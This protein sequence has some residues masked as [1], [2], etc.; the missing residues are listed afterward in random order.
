MKF[1]KFVLI[2][3]ACV[4]LVISSISIYLGPDDLAKC[5]QTPSEGAGCEEADAIVAVSGGDTSARTEEAIKLYK[6]GWSTY[7]IFSGA[8]AD[9]SGPSN[10][11]VMRRQAIA[12][13]VDP[14]RIIIDEVSSTTEEN[15]KETKSIFDQ[16]KIKS[17]IIVTSQ[18]HQRRAMLEFQKRATDVSVRSSPTTYDE[19]WGIWWWLTPGGWITALAELFRSLYLQFGGAP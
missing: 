18:Y 15:A 14:Q 7:L 3:A 17:A 4:V 12:A 5:D 13:K 6:N 9:K 11:A 19:N 10:A 2:V 16:Y 8:A 1:V